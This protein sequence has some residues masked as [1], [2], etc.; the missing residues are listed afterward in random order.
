MSAAHEY[1]IKTLLK[2]FGISMDDLHPA[3]I[4]P[5]LIETAGLDQEQMQMI[6]LKAQQILIDYDRNQVQLNMRLQAIMDALKIVDPVLLASIQIQER[7]NE[8]DS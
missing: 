6:V 8:N 3:N 7:E 4:I 1:M 5:K 2:A